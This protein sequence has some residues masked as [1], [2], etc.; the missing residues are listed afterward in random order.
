MSE[1]KNELLFSRFGIKYGDLPAMF[2]RGSILLRERV[3]VP[4]EEDGAG[5]AGGAGAADEAEGAAKPA[6][7]AATG[8]DAEAHDGGGAPPAKRARKPP[9]SKP[10]G[11][12]AKRVI[13][14]VHEDLIGPAFWKKRP[15]LLGRQR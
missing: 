15:N 2:R 10:K 8:G 9:A 1:D 13:S 6:A 14:V 7:T 12:A 5:G 4:T 11:R 3:A